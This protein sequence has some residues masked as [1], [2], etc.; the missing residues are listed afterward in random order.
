MDGQQAW[1]RILAAMPVTERR[2][3]LAGISTPVLE[4][5]EGPPI[6]LLHGQG[7]FAAVWI[8][9]IDGLAATH[10]VIVPDLPGQGASDATD[11][12]LDRARVL[13]W[14]DQL[15]DATC[16]APP[17]L[18]GHLLGGA[19]AARYA[20]RRSDRLAHLVLL[21]TM[22]LG[23]FRPRPSFALPMIGFMAKP[24]ERSRD[25]LFDRCFFDMDQVGKQVGEP[26]EA[27]LTYALDR[28][29]SS[30][31]QAALRRLLRLGMSPIPA[32]DLARIKVPTTLI[33]GRH[34]L[35]VSLRTAESASRKHGWPLHV[36]E[37]CRDDPAAEQPE[38]FVH[39]L[40]A[41]LSRA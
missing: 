2:L 41:A 33:H 24:T 22:G 26:W 5:G 25:R 36:I 11:V 30:S 20:T 7:E 14:L 27:L 38:A 10:R 34:D 21:D 19:I 31:V 39:E 37:D 9:V 23:W 35:Q 32:E 40:H 28:A 6:V 12:T 17:V 16:A 4:C 3:T 18:V 13:G 1:E 8:N 15:I 29:R